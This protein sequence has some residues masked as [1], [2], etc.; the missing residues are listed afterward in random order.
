MSN[1]NIRYSLNM[2]FHDNTKYVVPII[3]ECLKSI[4]PLA[5]HLRVYLYRMCDYVCSSTSVSPVDKCQ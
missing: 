3:L 1:L 5:G 4:A 2:L